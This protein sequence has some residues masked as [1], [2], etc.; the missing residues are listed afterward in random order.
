MNGYIVPMKNKLQ[1]AQSWSCL[2]EI[3]TFSLERCRS[4]GEKSLGFLHDVKVAA[5]RRREEKSCVQAKS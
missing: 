5:V 2:V 1:A 4:A 3:T